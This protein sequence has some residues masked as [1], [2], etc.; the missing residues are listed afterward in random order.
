VIVFRT[1]PWIQAGTLRASGTGAVRID[2]PE[3]ALKV[4]VGS[5]VVAD[6][7]FR[8]RSGWD[9]RVIHVPGS[10]LQSA[11]IRLRVRGRYAS[12][13]YWFFQ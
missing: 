10:S 6:E 2:F 13:Y 9:E 11:P 5:A 8:P 3:A 12:F 4:D 7:T 1:A